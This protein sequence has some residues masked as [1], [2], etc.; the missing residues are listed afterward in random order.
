MAARTVAVEELEGQAAADLLGRVAR[1]R[2]AITV[3]FPDGE[4]VEIRP[5]ALQ[6]LPALDGHVPAGWKDAAYGE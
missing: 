3:V 6:P 2:E 4:S 5:S 1:D